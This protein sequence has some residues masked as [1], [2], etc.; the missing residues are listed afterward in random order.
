[1]SQDVLCFKI[2]YGSGFTGGRWSRKSIVSAMERDLSKRGY[3]ILRTYAQ[4]GGSGTAFLYFELPDGE[5]E[6]S[7]AAS[8]L[9]EAVRENLVS[10]MNVT[11][12]VSSSIE[13]F[14]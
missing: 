14:F 6:R 10:G 5:S 3:K 13:N 11:S 7:E 9:S 1:M 4:R 12:Y 8:K 2:S